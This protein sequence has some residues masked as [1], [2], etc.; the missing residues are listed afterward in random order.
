MEWTSQRNGDLG[1]YTDSQWSNNR[2]ETRRADDMFIF[3]DPTPF[4]ARVMAKLWSKQ[5]KTYPWMGWTYA[6]RF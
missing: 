1:G 2:I 3:V 4:P 5:A 6:T